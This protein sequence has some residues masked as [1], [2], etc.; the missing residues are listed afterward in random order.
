MAVDAK[1]ERPRDADQV[2]AEIER[3]REQI[4]SSMM[5]LRHEVSQAADWRRWVRQRPGLWLG[6]AFAVGFYLGTRE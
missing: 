4:Q 3:A 2:R 5:A 6:A 1:L